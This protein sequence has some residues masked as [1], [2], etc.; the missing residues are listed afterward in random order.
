MPEAPLTPVGALGRRDRVLISGCLAVTVLLAWTYLVYLARQMSA[1]T[2]YEAAMR[3]M[4]P[5][6]GWSLPDVFFTFVMWA[7]MMLGMMGTAAWP[8][9]TLFASARVSR[10]AAARSGVLVFA[11]G[12][13]V[14]WTGFSAAAAGAQW[15]LHE[16]AW[17]SDSMSIAGPRLAGGILVAAGIYQVTSW[18]NACLTHCRSPLGFLMTNWRDGTLGAFTMGLRH[19]AWCLGCCWALML[20][21]FAV[22]VMNLVWVFLLAGVVLLEKVSPMG[23]I[24]ARLVGAALMLFGTVVAF[25]R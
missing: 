14:V 13:F 1:S 17:L 5:M 24:G 22:G 16:G 2:P 25:H 19:G 9:L 10:G 21:L 18:K 12:Y 23:R 7:V 15:G 11:L 3:S 20:V 4:G 6:P 8:V